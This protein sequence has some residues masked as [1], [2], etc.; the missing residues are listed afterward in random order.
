MHKL[1]NICDIFVAFIIK[2]IIIIIIYYLNIVKFVQFQVKRINLDDM[3]TSNYF[4]LS[5]YFRFLV[6]QGSVAAQL[7]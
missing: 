2:I 5:S 1:R 3:S 4:I 6:L 7:R